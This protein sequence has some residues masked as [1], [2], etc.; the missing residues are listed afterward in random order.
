MHLL[1]MAGGVGGAKLALGLS[2]RLTPDELTIVV[3]TGDDETF[4]GLHVSPDLDTVM[5]TLAGLANPETGWGL[6]GES[7]RALGTLEARAGIH[8][9]VMRGRMEMTGSSMKAPFEDRY[10][11]EGGADER[12]V[13]PITETHTQRTREAS[14]RVP[15]LLELREDRAATQPDGRFVERDATPFNMAVLW[16]YLE[17]HG[18]MEEVYTDRDSMFVAAPRKGETPAERKGQ[19]GS[20]DRSER[21][22]TYNFPQ[23]RVSDHRINLTLHK[24]PQIIEGEALGEII[25]ALVT[26]HQ[27][28]LL[29]ESS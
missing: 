21:I 20:G 7:F 11:V 24:L 12:I 2:R 14:E 27:A 19:V 13:V 8:G 23:G 22:R 16:E 1:A 10:R 18:R 9:V 6:A 29:A 5:Y 28:E 25:D 3:N 17:Q 4:H 15:G 26:E